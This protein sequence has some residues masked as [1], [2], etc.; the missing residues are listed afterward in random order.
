MD[1][2]GGDDDEGCRPCARTSEERRT[3]LGGCGDGDGKSYRLCHF[4]L[5]A[6]APAEGWASEGRRRSIVGGGGNEEGC[7]PRAHGGKKEEE[8]GRRR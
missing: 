8:Q 3:E 4:R 6:D 5:R 1:G 7:R 2:G